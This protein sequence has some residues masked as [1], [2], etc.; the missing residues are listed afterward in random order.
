MARLKLFNFQCH[1][2]VIRWVQVLKCDSLSSH[3]LAI[4]TVFTISTTQS[5]GNT[6]LEFRTDRVT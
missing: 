2:I 1:V 3:G 6:F 4:K 5:I